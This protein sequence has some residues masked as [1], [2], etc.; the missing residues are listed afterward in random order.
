MVA[1][2]DYD[3]IHHFVHED[4]VFYPKNSFECK[5]CA[6]VII[7]IRRCNNFFDLTPLFRG[8]KLFLAILLNLFQKPLLLRLI[9][10]IVTIPEP[11]RNSHFFLLVRISKLVFNF[12]LLWALL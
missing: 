3:V 7:K 8:F 9:K 1:T 4:A 11:A 6:L 5:Y 10:I 12:W 2:C